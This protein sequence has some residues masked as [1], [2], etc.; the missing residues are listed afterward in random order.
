[1]KFLKILLNV[2]KIL[3][4]VACIF[5][6][7]IF[8]VV[9]VLG[10][11]QDDPAI[12]GAVISLTIGLLSAFIAFKIIKSLKNSG[13]P[14]NNSES[15][16]HTV[17]GQE[18][19]RSANEDTLPSGNTFEKQLEID[20][21]DA[22]EYERNSVNPKFHRTQRE[23]DLSFNFSV[24]YSDEIQ[25]FDDDIYLQVSK[26]RKINNIDHKIMQCQKAIDVFYKAKACCYNKG[27]GGTIYFQDMWEHLHNSKNSNFS[28]IES[29]EKELL[30]MTTDYETAKQKLADIKLKNE[31]K[32]LIKQFNEHVDK[33]LVEL[34]EKNSGI[35][36][37]DL[38]P[39][40][41]EFYLPS[42]KRAIKKLS[43]NGTIIREKS[44]STYKLFLNK[45]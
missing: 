45:N 11:T 1:M 16:T 15:S 25:R 30:F 9:S 14:L 23:K 17:M 42:T 7:L 43:D 5:F 29:V 19:R 28:Y 2:A 32:L 41:E 33:F 21:R 34:I 27:K 26:I 31:R 22:I 40:F 39:H 4:L 6:A 24:K 10:V 36:Q 20:Y 12:F 8:F 35:L 18:A 38:Y 37:T 44:G 3:V 13:L